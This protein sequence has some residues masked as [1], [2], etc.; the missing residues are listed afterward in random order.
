M[1]KTLKVPG[2]WKFKK[3]YFTYFL[4]LNKD[5]ELKLYSSAPIAAIVLPAVRPYLVSWIIVTPST[6]LHE[7]MC[8]ESFAYD[9]QPQ[10]CKT[11]LAVVH[12]EAF[13]F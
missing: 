10:F 3:L 11:L 4:L 13:C 2:V 6:D 1:A 9:I 8:R 7:P 12:I 5:N